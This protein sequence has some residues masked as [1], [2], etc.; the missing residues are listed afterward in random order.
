MH[1]RATGDARLISDHR[2]RGTG[3]AML[4]KATNSRLENRLTCQRALFSLPA[5][6]D[7]PCSAPISART[8]RRSLS[9]LSCCSP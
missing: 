5:I 1:H 2:S 8:W 7:A 9:L 4:D 6:A 3:I